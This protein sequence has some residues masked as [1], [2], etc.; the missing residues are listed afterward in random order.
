MASSVPRLI[1]CYIKQYSKSTM[2]CVSRE[3]FCAHTSQKGH[4]TGGQIADMSCV[5]VAHGPGL[6][7]GS[8]PHAPVRS[9]HPARHVR[10]GCEKACGTPV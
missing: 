6:G 8:I 3:A 7:A 10:E 5:Q 1:K 4:A 9:H 2:L